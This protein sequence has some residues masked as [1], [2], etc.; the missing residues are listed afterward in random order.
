MA[1]AHI[2]ARNCAQSATTRQCGTHERGGQTQRGAGRSSS[3]A[4]CL[5]TALASVAPKSVKART[6]PRCSVT[7]ASVG[8]LDTP[9]RRVC[10]HGAA[11]HPRSAARAKTWNSRTHRHT[12]QTPRAT[13]VHSITHWH[14]QD[15]GAR[16]DDARASACIEDAPRRRRNTRRQAGAVAPATAQGGRAAPTLG[17][18]HQWRRNCSAQNDEAQCP[19]S[20]T[21]VQSSRQES[22]RC[23]TNKW[24]PGHSCHGRCIHCRTA[25]PL[26]Q[27]S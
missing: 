8:A 21:H 12:R 2:W 18:A 1:R 16:G 5:L 15:N 13:A 9:V 20:L 14:G 26:P 7:Q 11:L 25:P 24:R 23:R 19:R 22:T 27:C 10:P 4:A 6:Q 17:S 3:N